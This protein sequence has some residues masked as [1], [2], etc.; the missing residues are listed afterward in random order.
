MLHVDPSLLGRY[1]ANLKME[2]DTY[3]EPLSLHHVQNGIVQVNREYGLLLLEALLDCPDPHQAD[4]SAFARVL[5]SMDIED[6]RVLEAYLDRYFEELH[7]FKKT[8][9]LVFKNLE[10]VVRSE[11]FVS[12]S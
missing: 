4:L 6:G 5:V 1:F 2:R 3:E 7:E 12:F 8:N 9:L 11:C 10:F